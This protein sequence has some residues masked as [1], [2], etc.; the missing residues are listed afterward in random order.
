MQVCPDCLER[1]EGAGLTHYKIAFVSPIV[2]VASVTT[3]RASVI[4]LYIHIFQTRSFRIV[5]YG[6][7]AFNVLFFASAVVAECLICRPIAYRWDYTIQG[8]TCGNLKARDL[9]IAV[10]NLI[11]DAVV[12]VLPMPVLWR[13]QMATGRKLIVSCIL[14]LG[15][16]YELPFPP[17]PSLHS[18]NPLH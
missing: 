16:T 2:W 3:I 6:A 7:L 5:C 8:G 12:V 17:F 14:G 13:L 11:Q 9:S 4:A 18:K 1:I 15:I 10:I